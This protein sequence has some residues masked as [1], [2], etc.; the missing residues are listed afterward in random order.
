MLVQFHI[1]FLQTEEGFL[2]LDL[3]LVC[4]NCAVLCS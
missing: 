1:S 4:A 2:L 3:F